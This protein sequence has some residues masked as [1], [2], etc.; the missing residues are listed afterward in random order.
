MA[1]GILCKYQTKKDLAKYLSAACFSPA[2]ST[3]LQTIRIK[4]FMSWSGLSVNLINT[5][6]PK[7]IA[8]VKEYFDQDSK[9]YNQPKNLLRMK[10]WTLPRRRTISA[11]TTFFAQYLIPKNFHPKHTWIKQDNSPANL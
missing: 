3:F 7:S 1:N 8:T 10:S 4:H 11:R 6:L 2:P 5:H 9:V